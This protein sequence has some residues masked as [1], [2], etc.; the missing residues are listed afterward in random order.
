MEWCGHAAVHVSINNIG[1]DLMGPN[2]INTTLEV[3]ANRD[4]TL[5]GPMRLT[6]GFIGILGRFPV[7]LPNGTDPTAPPSLSDPYCMSTHF[8][9]C[10]RRFQFSVSNL[11]C[12]GVGMVG[13]II[14]SLVK[15]DQ[16][17]SLGN[18]NSLRGT[19]ICFFMPSLPAMLAPSFCSDPSEHHLR[20]NALGN[21]SLLYTLG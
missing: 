4:L 11:I 13:G 16:L 15:I 8:A 21:I 3:I 14:S 19:F 2:F 7:F 17:I 18:L 6:Q 9:Y 12:C 5:I 1:A 20:P 10:F